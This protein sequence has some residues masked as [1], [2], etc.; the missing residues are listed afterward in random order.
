[1]SQNND[2]DDE[3]EVEEKERGLN[4]RQKIA[5]VLAKLSGDF[6]ISCGGVTPLP[7]HPGLEI[8]GVGPI[9]L[10]LNEPQVRE[11]LKVAKPALLPSGTISESMWVL[12][13]SQVKFVNPEY[14]ESIVPHLH[15]FLTDSCSCISIKSDV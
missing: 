2:E 4:P 3:G 11:I 8:E 15:L 1:M 5:S 14:K 12:Q 13:P 6:E 7:P 10:P 9:G